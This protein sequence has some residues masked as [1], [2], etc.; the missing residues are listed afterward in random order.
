MELWSFSLSRAGNA[1]LWVWAIICL[2]Y[3]TV[4]SHAGRVCQNE[5]M[6]LLL[7]MEQGWALGR[8]TSH[9][10]CREVPEA[11]LPAEPWMSSPLP[12]IAPTTA[13]NCIALPSVLAPLLSCA[14]VILGSFFSGHREGCSLSEH[15][16]FLLPSGVDL[17]SSASGRVWTQ[18]SCFLALGFYR[19]HCC[20]CPKQNSQNCFLCVICL[21]CKYCARSECTQF[22]TPAQKHLLICMNMDCTTARNSRNF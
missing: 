5:E 19:G 15:R 1:R 10:S 9:L 3:V 20:F 12:R 4:G 18:H 21:L 7:L 8:T 17:N 22:D 11:E 13:F 6:L 16:S 2:C 14:W